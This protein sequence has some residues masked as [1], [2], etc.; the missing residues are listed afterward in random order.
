MTLQR[1]G[2]PPV[3]KDGTVVPLS[4][5]V[6]A[7][8][9]IYLSGVL[10]FRPDG[11]LAEDDVAAQTH[12]CFANMARVLE[13]AGAGLE[14]IAKVTVWLVRKE[15]FPAFNAAYAENVGD[16]PPARST[17]CAALMVPDALVE[18]EAIAI[19]P[20]DA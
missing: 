9:H 11:S 12:Q 1:L 8:Q 10:P 5:A 19:A 16:Q 6:R 20:A 2:K 15:D 14:D 17:V 4:P 3:L 18:I 13:M 7:G